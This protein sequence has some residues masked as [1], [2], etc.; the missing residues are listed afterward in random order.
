MNAIPQEKKKKKGEM[1]ITDNLL[2]SIS[3]SRPLAVFGV[4]PLKQH[5]PFRAPWDSAWL[6]AGVRTF[7]KYHASK[8]D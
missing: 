5:T 2:S 6:S 8:R 3:Y 1:K 4:P 7:L